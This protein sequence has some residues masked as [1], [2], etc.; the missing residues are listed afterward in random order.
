MLD[1]PTLVLNKNWTAVRTTTVRQAVI[2]LCRSAARII[3]PTSYEIYDLA[4]WLARSAIW[5]RYRS[6]RRADP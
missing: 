5:R 3:C 2:L 4:G 6:S 1:L